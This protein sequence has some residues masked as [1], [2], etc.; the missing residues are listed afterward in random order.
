MAVMSR[1]KRFARDLKARAIAP[2][3][4]GCADI[5]FRRES[6]WSGF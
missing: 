5:R 3:L 2:L 1:A 6:N 4:T